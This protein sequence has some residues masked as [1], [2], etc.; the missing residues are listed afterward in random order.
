[1]PAHTPRAAIGTRAPRRGARAAVR[2][3]ARAAG[4][5]GG[6]GGGTVAAPPAWRH[7][8]S[9]RS[10]SG[11]SWR[12]RRRGR[13]RTRRSGT[14]AC[15]GRRRRSSSAGMRTRRSR[16]RRPR[17]TRRPAAAART[18]RTPA[19]APRRGPARAAWRGPVAARGGVLSQQA[20]RSEGTG[21]PGA[22]PCARQSCVPFTAGCRVAAIL[23]MGCNVLGS[24][25][26]WPLTQLL[27]V[28]WGNISLS[29]ASCGRAPGRLHPALAV[30][31]GATSHLTNVTTT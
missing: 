24:L 15:A 9:R 1:M 11:R 25:G 18:A 17:T 29:W 3:A 12:G 26:T 30:R 14:A 22:G 6:G 7:S 19:R 31:A 16:R 8:S 21:S 23:Q 27:Q 20:Q 10:R 4:A 13:C 28:Y 2:A 5:G